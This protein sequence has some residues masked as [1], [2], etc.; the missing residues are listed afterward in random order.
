MAFVTCERIGKVALLR[1]DCPRANALSLQVLAEI[2]GAVEALSSQ[3]PGAVV[4]TGTERVFS[5]GA[6]IAELGGPERGREVSGAFTRALG[7][8]AAFPRATV[9]AISGPALGGGLE[10]ALACDFRLAAAGA[11][12]GQP[13]VLLGITPGGGATQRLPRLVGPALAKELILTGRQLTAEEALGYGLVNRVVAPPRTVLDEAMS[14]ATGL[15]EGAVVAQA[16][17]KQ[18][19]DEGL[20]GG[21]ARG[22][23]LES[24][25]F[26][27]AFE[28]RD[29]VTGLRSFLEHG[30]G[31]AEF[32]GQ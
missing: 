15:S 7:A 24:E 17:A 28:T 13:E 1:L 3:L 21:L 19:I 8:L 2:L 25:M 11:R 32:A 9:A 12:L 22:L 6:D 18:A 4:V 30:P 10:L 26:A 14:F 5:A 20:E 16:L 27:Q 23:A 31:K 29:A